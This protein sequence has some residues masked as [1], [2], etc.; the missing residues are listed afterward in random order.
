MQTAQRRRSTVSDREG[1]RETENWKYLKY[2]NKIG[3]SFDRSATS[4]HQVVA[5]FTKKKM[6]ARLGNSRSCNLLSVFSYLSHQSVCV[7]Q[8]GV[9]IHSHTHSIYIYNIGVALYTIAASLGEQQCWRCTRFSLHLSILIPS[10]PLS[11]ALLLLLKIYRRR[12]RK[13]SLRGIEKMETKKRKKK[14]RRRRQRPATTTSLVC[15]GHVV[16]A[17]AKK[18]QKPNESKSINFDVEI[19]CWVFGACGGWE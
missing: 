3:N 4:A 5:K 1:E 17:T 7:R 9:C 11:L 10:S 19:M 18:K 13:I 8:C 2:E 12:E 15:K 14:W 6:Y 16:C